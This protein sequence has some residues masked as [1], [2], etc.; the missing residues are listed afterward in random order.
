[1]TTVLF[2]ALCTFLAM[3]LGQGTDFRPDVPP[4]YSSLA[5]VRAAVEDRCDEIEVRDLDLLLDVARESQRQIDC[6]G[7]EY[8]GRKR[9]MELMFS[10]DELDL[11]IVLIEP[12]EYESLALQFRETYGEVTHDSVV[13]QFFYYSAV[14][15]RTRPHE[16]VFV[17]KRA[18]ANYQVYM[19]SMAREAGGG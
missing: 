9:F 3:L 8:R 15:S 17:S 10:D 5:E 19:D 4:F 16:V 18:R 14:A 13:G 7:F 2:P 11:V 1:M 12:E 6:T